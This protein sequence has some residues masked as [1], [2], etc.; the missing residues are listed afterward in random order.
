[1]LFPL[2]EYFPWWYFYGFDFSTNAIRLLN[3]RAATMRVPLSVCVADL[4]DTQHFPLPLLSPVESSDGNVA[5]LSSPLCCQVSS[6]IVNPDLAERIVSDQERS[7][8]SNHDLE[9]PTSSDTQI[10]GGFCCFCV[11]CDQNLLDH[12]D[13]SDLAHMIFSSTDVNEQRDRISKIPS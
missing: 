7:S 8:F 5:V 10:P 6:D 1:M 11:E 2:I 13:I 4:C 9:H 12:Y 3:Q